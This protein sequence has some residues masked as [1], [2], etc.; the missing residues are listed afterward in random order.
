MA[1]NEKF[2]RRML[3]IDEAAPY[4]GPMRRR[5][6]RLITDHKLSKRKIDRSTFF[7]DVDRDARLDAR[8]SDGTRSALARTGGVVRP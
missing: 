3:T 5:V 7:A 6:R 2:R 4:L 8:R 1:R